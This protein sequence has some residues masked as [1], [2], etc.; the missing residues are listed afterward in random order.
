MVYGDV[1]VVYDFFGMMFVMLVGCLFVLYKEL[2]TLQV[3]MMMQM[4]GMARSSS[5]LHTHHTLFL[6]SLSMWNSNI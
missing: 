3:S 6:N 2:I 4:T 1:C 5:L